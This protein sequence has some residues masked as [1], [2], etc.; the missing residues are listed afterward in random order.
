MVGCDKATPVAPNGTIL[1][2]SANPSKIGINGRSTITV[3]GRKPDG[4]P[5][6]PGTEV[7]MSASLG[8]IDS[9]ITTDRNGVATATFRS[10]G[11]LGVAKISATTGGATGGGGTSGGGTTGGGGSSS[12]PLTATIEVQVG[13]AAKTIS[14]QPTPTT[15]PSNGGTVTLLAIVRDASGQPLAN[16]GV[17]FT[18]DVG[19][20][21]SRGAIVQTNA[22]GQARDTLTITEADLAGNVSAIDVSAQTAGGDGALITDTFQ[23]RVQGG[24]PVASFEY[25]KGSTAN[26]VLFT[27]TSTGGVGQ[28]TYSWDFGDNTSSNEPSPAHTYATGGTYNVRLT[29]VD[30]SGQ[31]DT[32]TAR[33]TVPVTQPGT[34][35]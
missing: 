6:N 27:D 35:S 5:L 17:N 25:D 33:I 24:R 14:L 19:R 2:I 18:T 34:G 9:I 10:D 28:L 4:N 21:N 26:Q 8:S 23:I 29:V 13:E 22:N 15:V 12:G 31:S 3:I 30:E 20:L 7:R 11:R 16:Q 32:A 1:T